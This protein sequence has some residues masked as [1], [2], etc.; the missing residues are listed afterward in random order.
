[1]IAAFLFPMV[2][3]R[4]AANIVSWWTVPEGEFNIGMSSD[5]SFSTFLMS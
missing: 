3:Y 4:L 1:M 5:M 2:A